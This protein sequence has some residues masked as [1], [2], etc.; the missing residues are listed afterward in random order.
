MKTFV[1]QPVKTTRFRKWKMAPDRRWMFRTLTFRATPLK[2]IF[3]FQKF[4]NT[5]HSTISEKKKLKKIPTNFD[6]SVAGT[7][8]ELRVGPNVPPSCCWPIGRPAAHLRPL[9]YGQPQTD[10][11]RLWI[12]S[13]WRVVT[14]F[15]SL[16][17]VILQVKI[18]IQ[19][20]CFKIGQLVRQEWEILQSKTLKWSSLIKK[21]I[22]KK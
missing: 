10:D 18:Q 13:A 20:K 11:R 15:F 7:S 3:F 1:T 9:I 16:F 4:K 14:F 19:I 21:K 8:G 5:K 6:Y 22:K 17:V 2:T 12:I